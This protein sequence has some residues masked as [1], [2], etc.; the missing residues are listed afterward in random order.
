MVGWG[1][2]RWRRQVI[3]VS[4]EEGEH[5]KRAYYRISGTLMC[6]R[7]EREAI[8]DTSEVTLL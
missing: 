8:K 3:I 4:K 7:K 1:V 6:I 2:S 5:W